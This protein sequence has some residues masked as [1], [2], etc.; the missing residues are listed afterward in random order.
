MWGR[1]MD[2]SSVNDE[3]SGKRSGPHV[4]KRL[5]A[6]FVKKAPPGRHTD[7]GGLYLQVDKSGARR[8]LL[9]VV[10]HGKRRDF[11][12]GTA[13][14]VSLAD[15][16]EKAYEIRRV[17]AAGGNP[18]VRKREEQGRATTFAE[19]AKRVHHRKF[20]DNKN[21]G[22]HIA[23]WIN[24]L[25]TYA[26]PI[27]G[28]LSVEDVNQDDIDRVIDPIWTEKP[29]TARRVLQRIKTVFDHA[30]GMGLRTR[31]NPATGLR[32]LM[33]EQGD[34][35]KHFSAIPFIEI[36][37]LVS[38]FRESN[39]VGPMALLFTLFTAS[40]SGPV[41]AA[42]W[43]EF[44]EN[45]QEWKIPG[46]KMKTKKKFVVPISMPAR[47]IL[48][49]ARKRRTN[50]SDLVFPSPSKPKNMISENTMR[51]SLQTVFPEA[52]VH[53]LRATFRTW[54]TEIIRV[55]QDIAEM[56]LAHALGGKVERSYNRPDM[57]A[58]RLMMLEKWGLW[59]TG[60]LEPFSNGNDIEAYIRG[61]WMEPT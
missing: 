32:G 31:G 58:E 13:M 51:K 59:A 8:W 33:R 38:A 24:T 30:C 39:D 61:L 29:E 6:A 44:D 15:A 1:K 35:V 11:G 46:T 22:K 52:T 47:E 18:K 49:R 12:L 17:I 5:N 41:R 26:F 20:K 10:V 43:S 53:G 16:R 2:G 36:D 19:L 54:V 28:D 42:T 27:L 60:D 55:D 48:V 21:N 23:Q 4:E 56:C 57:V 7:G 3:R 40:R 34:Q 14:V 9:R 37:R 45:L 25:E 50:A